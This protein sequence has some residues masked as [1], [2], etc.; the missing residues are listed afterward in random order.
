[1][2]IYVL[3]LHFG[4]SKTLSGEGAWLFSIAIQRHADEY[5]SVV[6]S[7]FCLCPILQVTIFSVR[8]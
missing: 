5:S 2:V 7:I 4:G 1:M 3:S 6:H 8:E